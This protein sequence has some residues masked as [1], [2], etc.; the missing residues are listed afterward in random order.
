MVKVMMPMHDKYENEKV[1][2]LIPSQ[3]KKVQ[4]CLGLL[5]YKIKLSPCLTKHH[6]MKEC[7]GSGSIAPLIL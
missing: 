7:W 6:A 4:Q 1:L 3:I 2:I 5:E